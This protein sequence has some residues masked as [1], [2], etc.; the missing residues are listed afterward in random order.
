MSSFDGEEIDEKDRFAFRE[1][2]LLFRRLEL[3]STY[4]FFDRLVST[5]WNEGTQRVHICATLR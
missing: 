5:P 4:K 2:Q 1:D 3:Y